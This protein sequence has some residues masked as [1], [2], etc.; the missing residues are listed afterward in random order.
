MDWDRVTTQARRYRE[1]IEAF[2]PTYLDEIAGIAEGAGVSV[3]DVLAINVRTEVM[4]AAKAL[5]EF[6]SKRSPVRA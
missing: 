6:L 4:F 1:P 5:A 2:G 3:D